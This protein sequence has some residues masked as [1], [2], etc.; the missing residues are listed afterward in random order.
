MRF[1]FTH[2]HLVFPIGDTSKPGGSKPGSSSSNTAA[3]ATQVFFK[4]G[5]DD[6]SIS[7]EQSPVSSPTLSASAQEVIGMETSRG[8]TESGESEENITTTLS[9]SSS[10]MSEETEQFS[11]DEEFC[12]I[13]DPGLGISVRQ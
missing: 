10:S 2:N 1:C 3:A 6:L 7:V 12:I 9:S 4:P 5:S 11:T 8:M 13:D